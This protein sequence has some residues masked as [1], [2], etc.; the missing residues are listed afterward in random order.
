MM[1]SY[2]G[3][4]TPEMTSSGYKTKLQQTIL[5][6]NGSPKVQMILYVNTECDHSIKPDKARWNWTWTWKYWIQMEDEHEVLLDQTTQQ[7]PGTD[8]EL[9]PT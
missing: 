9:K 4:M 2:T 8:P 3:H 5:N 6:P 1:S 7:E